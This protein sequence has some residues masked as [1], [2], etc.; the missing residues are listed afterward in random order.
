MIAQ[1]SHGVNRFHC[2][3]CGDHHPPSFQQS[4]VEALIQRHHDR[5]WLEQT[6]R[7][8]I[9]TG[10]L[11][12]VRAN[13][14][15]VAS[16]EHLDIL[17]CCGVRPHLLIHSG[18]HGN[19]G[20]RCQRDGGEQ[21]V[22]AALSESRDHIRRGGRNDHEIGPARQ[23]NVSHTRLGSFIKELGMRGLS[24]QCLHGQGRDEFRCASGQ[25]DAHHSALLFQQSY[26]LRAF[27][28]R[29]TAGNSDQNMALG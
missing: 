10:L 3:P 9:A 14:L 24:R 11:S 17:L 26:Q 12:R 19:R 8:D 29:D 21:I 4:I 15:N 7:T 20:R 25:Y 2:R 13:D 1:V 22:S 27:V 6:T 18:C 28:R 23:L 5:L 16:G